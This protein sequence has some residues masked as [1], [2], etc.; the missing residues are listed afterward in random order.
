MAEKL[1]YKNKLYFKYK[2]Q[3]IDLNIIFI[4]NPDPDSATR[5]NIK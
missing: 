5:E 4:N 2:R 1:I 3:N